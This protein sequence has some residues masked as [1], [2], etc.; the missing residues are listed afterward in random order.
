LRFWS[1]RG[2]WLV[3]ALV[4]DV[5]GLKPVLAES[6]LNPFAGRGRRMRMKFD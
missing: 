5:G 4:P 1:R 3:V 2:L 6:A